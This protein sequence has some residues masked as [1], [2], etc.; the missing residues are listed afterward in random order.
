[1]IICTFEVEM[2][3]IIY[4]RG[5]C[6]GTVDGNTNVTFSESVKKLVKSEKN[7]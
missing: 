3:E 1:M 4:D 5:N 7:I 2:P 6:T